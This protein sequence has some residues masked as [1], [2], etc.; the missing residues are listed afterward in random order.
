MIYIRMKTFCERNL[1]KTQDGK[2]QNK[3]NE[4][5]TDFTHVPY[6]QFVLCLLLDRK[7]ARAL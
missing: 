3:C 7:E 1:C 2:Q 4:H 6:L 5:F